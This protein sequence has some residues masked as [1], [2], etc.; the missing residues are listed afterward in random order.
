MPYREAAGLWQQLVQLENLY[1]ED[2][3]LIFDDGA[4]GTRLP[5]VMELAFGREVISLVEQP[6][7]DELA[8]LEQALADLQDEGKDAYFSVVDGDMKWESQRF[9]LVAHASQ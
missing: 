6:G 5:Q 3:V 7:A 9:G 2:A 8:R 4:Y 1:P